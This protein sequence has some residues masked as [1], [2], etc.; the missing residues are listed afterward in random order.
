MS[1]ML[2]THAM[3][4]RHIYGELDSRRIINKWGYSILSNRKKQTI[5]KVNILHR[6]VTISDDITFILKD[7]LWSHLRI[8]SNV[9][10]MI[11]P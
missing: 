8:I 6:P 5:R 1:G 3:D 7:N 2:N 4:N 10:A 9:I 11:N